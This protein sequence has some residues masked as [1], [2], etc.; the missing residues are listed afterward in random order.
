VTCV[1]IAASNLNVV[2]GLSIMLSRRSI[3]G[4]F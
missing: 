4:R 3:I 1:V 2:V